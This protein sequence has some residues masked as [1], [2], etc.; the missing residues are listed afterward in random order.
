MIVPTADRSK[1]TVMVKVRFSERDRRILPEMSARVAF[2]E[3]AVKADEE[4]PRT[5]VNPAALVTRNG[6]QI[7]FVVG[8]RRPWRDRGDAGEKIG[9][10]IEVLDGVK[11]GEKVV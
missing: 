3:R 7:V 10:I 6:K 4:S 1:A 11:P 2:L 5:A 9:D 8:E